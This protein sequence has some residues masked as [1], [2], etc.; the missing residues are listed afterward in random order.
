MKFGLVLIT[1][2]KMYKR[3]DRPPTGCGCEAIT[4][5][6]DHFSLNGIASRQLYDTIDY[7]R[8]TFY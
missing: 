1:L 5:E 8:V 4:I 6:A 3:T 7:M 2:L